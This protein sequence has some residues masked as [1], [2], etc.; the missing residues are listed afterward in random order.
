VTDFSSTQERHVLVVNDGKRRAIA[1]DAA[2]YSIGRDPSNAI[3]LNADTVSRQH[4][5]LLRVP[6]PSTRQYRYRLID[7]NAQGKPSANGVFVNDKPCRTCEL[8][9]GDS[10]RFGQTLEASYLTVLMGEVEFTNYLESIS[11]QSLKSDT[12]N[13]KETLVADCLS[14]EEIMAVSTTTIHDQGAKL[15]QRSTVAPWA[16]E[17]LHEGTKTKKPQFKA[18]SKAQLQEPRHQGTS[19]LWTIA[20]P[21]AVAAVA[22]L[23]GVGLLLSRGQLSKSSAASTPDASVSESTQK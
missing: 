22:I 13:A 20:I 1:L 14:M 8:T 4:A 12:I 7:G 19:R 9:H 23:V 16:A 6:V 21:S 18:Q 2:A 3:V 5:M 11:Y 10:V 15:R 17:T